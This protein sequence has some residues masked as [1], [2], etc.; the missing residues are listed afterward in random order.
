M[1]KFLYTW[2]EFTFSKFADIL[3][4]ENKEVKNENL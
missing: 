4:I 1:K 2:E 3:K